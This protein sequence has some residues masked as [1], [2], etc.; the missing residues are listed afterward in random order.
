MDFA[1]VCATKKRFKSNTGCIY[2]WFN[3]EGHAD[4][5]LHIQAFPGEPF[6]QV[7]RVHPDLFN[8]KYE[9]VTDPEE[10]ESQHRDPEP[11][12]KVVI[13]NGKIPRI[14]EVVRDYIA[15]ASKLCKSREKLAGMLGVNRKTLYYKLKQYEKSI[16]V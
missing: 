16:H 4:K 15:F 12:F 14:E 7:T 3:I 6:V 1:T 9:L 2:D 11:E 8:D 13:I 10:L 5:F